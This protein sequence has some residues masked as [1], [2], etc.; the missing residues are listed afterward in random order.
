MI[1]YIYIR[2]GGYGQKE[3]YKRQR[4]YFRYVDFIL[5]KHEFPYWE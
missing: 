3:N 1:G 5:N 4:N 2:A